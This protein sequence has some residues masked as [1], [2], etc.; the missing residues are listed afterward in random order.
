MGHCQLWMKLWHSPHSR[1]WHFNKDLRDLTKKCLVMGGYPGTKVG[2]QGKYL[3]SGIRVAGKVGA[4]CMPAAPPLH[5]FITPAKT[6]ELQAPHQ[7][8]G[9]PTLFAAHSHHPESLHHMAWRTAGLRECQQLPPLPE[10]EV[11]GAYPRIGPVSGLTG[12]YWYHTG[13]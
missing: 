1:P 7:K 13:T 2:Q 11:L 9:I 3:A 10:A 4:P 8:V 6:L 12:Q 5:N